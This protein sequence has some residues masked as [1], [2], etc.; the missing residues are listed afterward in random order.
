MRRLS[1]L[2]ALLASTQL[3]DNLRSFYSSYYKTGR[4]KGT[5]K[6]KESKAPIPDEVTR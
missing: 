6:M 3:S 1:A 2:T 4:T 5:G